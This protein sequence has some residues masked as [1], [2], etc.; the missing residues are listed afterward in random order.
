MRKIILIAAALLMSGMAYSAEKVPM[1][2]G[3]YL[4][5][6]TMEYRTPSVDFSASGKKLKVLFILNRTGARDAVELMQMMPCDYEAILTFDR[7]NFTTGS[8]E[9]FMKGTSFSEKRREFTRKLN[10]NYDVIIL[11]G[12]TLDKLPKAQQNRLIAKVRKGTPLLQVVLTKEDY[13]LH[14]NLTGNALKIPFKNWIDAEV[15]ANTADKG[16]VVNVVWNR[17]TPYNE[18]LSLVAEREFDSYHRSYY[19]SDLAN[20]AML[21]RFAADCPAIPDNPTVRIRDRHNNILSGKDLPG[22]RYF[23]DI[24]GKNGAFVIEPFDVASP[25]G[26]LSLVLPRQSRKTVFSGSAYWE[27][28]NAD[29]AG[30][31]V[32][33]V[34]SP[35]KQIWSRQIFP[36][37]KAAKSVN[38]KVDA[39]LL[40]SMAGFVRIA[41]LDKN[42]KPLIKTEQCVFFP[43]R[44]IEDYFQIAWASA[45]NELYAAQSVGRMNWRYVITAGWDSYVTRTA[46]LD[47]KLISYTS[48][49]TIF[50]R[51]DKNGV[52][53]KLNKKSADIADGD[54]C[55][56]RPESLEIWRQ[57]ARECFRELEPVMYCL[58]DE[59]GFSY[60]AGYGKQDQKYFREFLKNQYKT[61]DKLNYAW[62]KDFKSFDEVDVNF[63]RSPKNFTAWFDHRRYLEK[64]YSDVL[65]FMRDEIKKIDPAAPVGCEGSMPGDIELSMGSLEYWGPYQNNVYD[66][67]I[68]SFGKDKYRTSW[69]G[70]YMN[71]THGSRHDYP[72]L[73]VETLLKGSVNG[74][75]FFAS[76][77]GHNHGGIAADCRIAEYVQKWLPVMDMLKGGVAHYM[78]KNKLVNQGILIYWSHASRTA[79]ML[80]D[81]CGDPAART[82]IFGMNDDTL[83]MHDWSIA[84]WDA[85]VI[86]PIMRWAYHR[87]E[88]FDFVSSRTLERLTAPDA[89]VLFMMGCAALSDVEADAI[90]EFIKQGGT[91]IADFLPGILD[92]NLT[93]RK[94]GALSELFGTAGFAEAPKAKPGKVELAGFKA[95]K[96]FVA[97]K[98]VSVKNYGKGKAVLLNFA[99]QGAFASADKSTPFDAFIDSLVPLQKPCS[100]SPALTDGMVRI[101]KHENFTSYGILNILDPVW[102]PGLLQKD[103]LPGAKDRK[104]TVTVP[105]KKH[106]YKVGCGYV[107]FSN[108][109]TVDFNSDTLN[110]YSVFDKKQSNPDF[111]VKS[112][113]RGREV[114]WISPVLKKGRV[115]RLEVIDSEGKVVKMM[116]FDE[117]RPLWAFPLN[118]K[119]GKYTAKITDIATA[120]TAKTTFELK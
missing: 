65:H 44:T 110:L 32:E 102:R 19:L 23:R 74:N 20:V 106:I 94:T 2:D 11:G 84:F 69:W 58:G 27:K 49:N 41:L 12:F 80:D 37:A 93:P 6:L 43:D 47:Q 55:F 95:G 51:G 88:G 71:F 86:T 50:I 30:V 60:N 103:S 98:P 16:R 42:N 34:D 54:Y 70:G 22:G 46:Q 39:T 7:R 77:P 10:Q 118:C 45:R 111:A 56:Y 120:L 72:M 40:Q 75:A 29:V 89:K 48:G 76:Y 4:N 14:K 9:R 53:Q 68:R 5:K 116:V 117:K 91:V 35:Y 13:K 3:D 15:T 28:S 115:Y 83:N 61:L 78:I 90:K 67:I 97:G 26:K 112:A 57:E 105:E 17:P 104:F 8:Y 100:I 52:I 63:C 31:M 62:Q 59:L 85:E 99:L 33:M 107:G 64:M 73:H 87:G 92:E 96:T 36:V 119:V 21:A 1:R 114:E 38:F 109:F 66:E 79:L 25:V 81:R 113:E 108:S 101:R 24:I 82:K 18:P